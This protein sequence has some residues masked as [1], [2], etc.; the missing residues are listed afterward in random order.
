MRRLY[1]IFATV[2]VSLLVA[3]CVTES[4]DTREQSIEWHCNNMWYCTRQYFSF[5]EE[6]VT[7]ALCLDDAIV[8]ENFAIFAE[9]NPNATITQQGNVYHI[10]M[11]PDDYYYK[12]S[13]DIVVSTDG[14]SLTNGGVWYL[15]GDSELDYDVKLADLGDNRI[16]VEFRHLSYGTTSGTAQ[17]T[18]DYSRTDTLRCESLTYDGCFSLVDVSGSVQS[19]LYVSI[20]ANAMNY[21]TNGDNHRAGF[22]DGSTDAEFH[23][24][25]YGT[26]DVVH[27]EVI[28][29]ELLRIT[30]GDYT[31]QS[32]YY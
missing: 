14:R 16:S 28:D 29:R 12:M 3:G 10:S 27:F 13:Y 21:M 30:Y 17:L 8:N 24:T 7:I 2:L 11:Y 23:D 26:T 19:P 25:L 15:Q 9:L 32:R 31:F 18:V 4:G 20:V 22:V 5:T 6:V 1:S